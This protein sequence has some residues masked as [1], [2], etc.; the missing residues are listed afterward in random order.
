[1]N[2]TKFLTQ[3][4]HMNQASSLSLQAQS[5]SRSTTIP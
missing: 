2:K 5:T 3:E 1:S 4:H